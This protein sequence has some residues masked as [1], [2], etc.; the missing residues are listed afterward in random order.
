M[1]FILIAN[2][3]VGLLLAALAIPL[4]RRR[5]RPNGLYGLRCRATFENE[6][7]WYEANARSG[8]DLLFLAAGIVALSVLLRLL[9][10]MSPEIY[11]AAV[12]LSITVGALLLA[13]VGVS[14]ANGLLRIRQQR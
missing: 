6:W 8:R 4:V 14:R 5:I 2:L 3:L 1:D 11:A 10:G 12:A 13:V 7:V 9:P